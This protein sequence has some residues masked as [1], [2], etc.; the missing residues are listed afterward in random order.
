MFG[1]K[2]SVFILLLYVISTK[3]LKGLRAHPIWS[4]EDSPWRL[5]LENSF[6]EIRSE[7]LVFQRS[8]NSSN[9]RSC[10]P[11]SMIFQPYRAPKSSSSSSFSSS[12]SATSA[13]DSRGSLATDR[14]QWD[15]CYL[16]LHGM[17][18]AENEA[19]FPKTMHVIR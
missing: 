19:L 4:E 17:D 15:V 11:A 8:D 18:F 13:A 6:E 9:H 12:S 2:K 14:G 3:V 5:L 16:R 7:L 10:K 1:H